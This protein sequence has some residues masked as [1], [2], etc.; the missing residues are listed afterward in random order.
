MKLSIRIRIQPKMLDPDPESMNMDP[1][2]L[3][4][5][6]NIVQFNCTLSLTGTVIIILV[7]Y[8]TTCWLKLIYPTGYGEKSHNFYL[9]Q[10]TIPTF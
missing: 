2:P 4:T 8:V 5:G 7:H 6:Y 1:K 3:T 10:Q 9:R